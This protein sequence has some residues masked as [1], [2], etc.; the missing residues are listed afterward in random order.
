MNLPPEQEPDNEE[1]S[2]SDFQ[3]WEDHRLPDKTSVFEYSDSTRDH[4]DE[5]ESQKFHYEG[6]DLPEKM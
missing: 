5:G 2:P 1:K 4:I 3:E 6:N